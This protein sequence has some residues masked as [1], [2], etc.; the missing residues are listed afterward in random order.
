[1]ALDE[2]DLRHD[3]LEA[4]KLKARP[5]P[6]NDDLGSPRHDGLDTGDLPD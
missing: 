6:V 2:I 3:G 4:A 5:P 1:V